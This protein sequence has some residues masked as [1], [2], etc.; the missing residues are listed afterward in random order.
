MLRGCKSPLSAIVQ[1]IVTSQKHAG[2]RHLSSGDFIIGKLY[3]RKNMLIASLS[4]KI[5]SSFYRPNRPLSITT[6]S[7]LR[8]IGLDNN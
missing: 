8:T 1:H 6:P 5:Y 3:S 2:D 7:L 4:P